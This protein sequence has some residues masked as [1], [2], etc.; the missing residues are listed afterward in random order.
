MYKV[1]QTK[2]LYIYVKIIFHIFNF[3][4]SPAVMASYIPQKLV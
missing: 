2:H 1:K 4:D 3:Y